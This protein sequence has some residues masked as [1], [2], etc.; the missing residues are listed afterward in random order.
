[1][2]FVPSLGILQRRMISRELSISSHHLRSP[3]LINSGENQ[4]DEEVIEIMENGLFRQKNCA[5]TFRVTAKYLNM[6]NFEW[7]S[8]NFDRIQIKPGGWQKN[9]FN[10]F[11]LEKENC[12]IR[13]SYHEQK[14]SLK[15]SFRVESNL[16]ITITVITITVITIMVI[17]ITVITK[18]WL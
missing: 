14:L 4:H 18:S 15:V 13:L 2:I 1:M 12:W 17:M 8:R 11:L 6:L 7:R 10:S 5:I 3:K 9:S 16:F